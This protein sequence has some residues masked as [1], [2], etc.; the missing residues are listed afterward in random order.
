MARKDVMRG[1]SVVHLTTKANSF[2]AVSLC[3]RIG[4]VE[5]FVKSTGSAKKGGLNREIMQGK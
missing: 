1:D 2:A 5:L 4:E 3:C